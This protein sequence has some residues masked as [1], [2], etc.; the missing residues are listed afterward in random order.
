MVFWRERMDVWRESAAKCVVVEERRDCRE[1][2]RE[3]RRVAWES[4][5]VV[6][7]LSLE[8]EL[9]R[10]I[11]GVVCVAM[12]RWKSSVGSSSIDSSSSSAGF[13]LWRGGM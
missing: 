8:S 12:S 4:I 13:G 7:G 3:V 2:C 5:V 6:G 1:V 11:G 9:R 10:D